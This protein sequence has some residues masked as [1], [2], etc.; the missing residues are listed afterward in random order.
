MQIEEIEAL[1]ALT[2]KSAVE[3]ERIKLEHLKLAK[4]QLD[5]AALLAAGRIGQESRD[6]GDSGSFRKSRSP[7]GRLSKV[8]EGMLHKIEKDI[9]DLDDKVGDRLHVLDL[10]GDGQISVHELDTAV[11]QVLRTRVT[12]EEIRFLVSELD[13]DGDGRVSV[14][15]L[16][17]LLHRYREQAGVPAP[18]KL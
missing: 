6:S 3:P 4:E 18:D 9:D 17:Q 8:L 14:E 7:T 15:Q 2:R 10:D 1:E 5:V 16:S 13:E 12:E 11:R